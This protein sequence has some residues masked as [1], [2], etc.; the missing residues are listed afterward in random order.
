MDPTVWLGAVV[1]LSPP[2]SCRQQADRPDCMRAG[3]PF[4]KRVA[5]AVKRFWFPGPLYPHVD[6]RR[7]L[8]AP[9]PR[10]DARCPC[11][12]RESRSTSETLLMQMDTGS[13][14]PLP[15]G[16]THGAL[17][18]LSIH[19]CGPGRLMY[20]AFTA[21]RSERRPGKPSVLNR[22]LSRGVHRLVYSQIGR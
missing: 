8:A 15:P 16:P 2:I 17:A 18:G 20:L 13:S 14:A 1:V 9:L 21:C 12:N 10:S 11:R 3:T 5:S 4:R 6:P 19:V 22:Q 7:G